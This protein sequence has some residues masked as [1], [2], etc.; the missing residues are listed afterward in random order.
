MK[1]LPGLNVHDSCIK[2]NSGE[3]I[4][5]TLIAYLVTAI[6]IFLLYI[7]VWNTYNF[8]IKQRKYKVYPLL[9]FYILSYADILLRIY[10]SFW[11]VDV[12][13]YQQIFAVIGVMWI[14]VCIGI[15]QILVIVELTI[16]I[17]QSMRVYEMPDE[18]KI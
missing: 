14:K 8:L 5:A 15:A 10:H 7:T 3:V 11:M 12:I 13:E 18:K 17:E 1:P 4:G 9:L 6:F 2:F 16:R